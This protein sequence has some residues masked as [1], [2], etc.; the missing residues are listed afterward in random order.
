MDAFIYGNQSYAALVAGLAKQAGY[1]ILGHIDDFGK[2]P[3]LQY[4][5]LRSRILDLKASVFLG[6][7]YK[8]LGARMK[9]LETLLRDEI[10]LPNLVHPTAVV[11]ADVQ[12]GQGNVL[13]ALSMVDSFSK[14]GDGNVLWPQA[15][16]NHDG[17]VGSNNFFSPASCISGFCE[18]G[19]SC[20]V[21]SNATVVDN[22]K[23]PSRSF[24]K[25]GSLYKN[26]K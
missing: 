9:L 1:K 25:A 5:S 14:L 2:D 7:G 4:Q 15:A 26:S 24:V 21:G 19:D 20:F 18:I 12:L 3:K 10:S 23:V 6:I 8:D 11:A 22:C 13:M 17:K 16:I